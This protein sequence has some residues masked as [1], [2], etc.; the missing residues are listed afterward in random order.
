MNLFLAIKQKYADAIL[1]GKKTAELRRVAPRLLDP[2]SIIFL[3]VK[4]QIVGHVELDRLTHAPAEGL[5]RREWESYIST[6][7]D[8]SRSAVITYLSGARQ[9]CAMH[10]RCPVRYQAPLPGPGYVVQS[11][12]YTTQEPSPIR[13]S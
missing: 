5:P 3:V 11:F 6:L 7:A 9:P 1:D 13:K 12:S 4:Q 8:I 2:G 10:L